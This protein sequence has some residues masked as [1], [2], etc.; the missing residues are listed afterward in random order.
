M[1][2]VIARARL[3]GGD[4]AHTCWP[5]A[6]YLPFAKD[7]SW[8]ILDSGCARADVGYTYPKR[9]ANDRS[10]AVPRHAVPAAREPS[11]AICSRS[12]PTAFK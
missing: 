3:S 6:R 7:S 5:T 2:V 11:S 9:P 12:S 8:P 4:K 1:A 10:T